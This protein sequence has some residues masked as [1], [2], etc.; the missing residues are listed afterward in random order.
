MSIQS[1]PKTTGI[2]TEVF[3]ISG[4]NLV[5]LAWI[6]DEL[7]CGQT[8]NRVSFVF[9]VQSDLEGQG[10]SAPNTIGILT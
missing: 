10:Q 6:G 7:L 4:P 1:T 2:V 9:E 3:C 8:Q 5:F